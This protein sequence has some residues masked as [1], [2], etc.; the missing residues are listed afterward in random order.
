MS[1]SPNYI[2]R[3]FLIC[4]IMVIFFFSSCSEYNEISNMNSEIKRISKNRFELADSLIEDSYYINGQY[5][6]NVP[7]LSNG[8]YLY[9]WD[10]SAYPYLQFLDNREGLAGRYDSRLPIE[11]IKEILIYDDCFLAINEKR[12]AISFN[13]GSYE[14]D[15]SDKAT[16]NNR[17][18]TR[19]IVF[20]PVVWNR[21]LI[22]NVAVHYLGI[23]DKNITAGDETNATRIISGITKIA[24]AG[25]YKGGYYEEGEVKKKIL[26]GSNLYS[27]FMLD[28]LSGDYKW[29]S[30]DDYYKLLNLIRLNRSITFLDVSYDY[31]IYKDIKNLKEFNAY[32]ERLKSPSLNEKLN[33]S[34]D[35][36]N[37][38][39]FEN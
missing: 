35:S 28:L 22:H 26:I 4:C 24:M 13:N 16:C 5:F 11:N 14:L 10:N 8:M 17:N 6:F 25:Y 18:L 23:E 30:E 39:F 27:Y 36:Q 34:P 33:C 12:N 19:H 38:Q 2:W 37:S 7:R 29:L 9:Y 3:T 15:K 1:H 20:T 31:L 21:D 32:Y